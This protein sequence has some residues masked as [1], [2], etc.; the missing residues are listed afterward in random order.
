MMRPV[1]PDATPTGTVR[2][3]PAGVVPETAVPV[4]Q[5]ISAPRLHVAATATDAAGTSTDPPATAGTGSAASAEARPGGPGSLAAAS[6]TAGRGRVQCLHDQRS[7]LSLGR[8]NIAVDVD[9]VGVPAPTT[10]GTHG[11]GDACRNDHP[12]RCRH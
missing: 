1:H 2:A 12:V 10:P 7:Q 8:Q 9:D 5:V 6:A 11:R 4:I 3:G